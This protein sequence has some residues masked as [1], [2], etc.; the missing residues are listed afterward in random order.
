MVGTMNIQLGI[1]TPVL[2]GDI[3]TADRR[4]SS[5]GPSVAHFCRFHLR[6]EKVPPSW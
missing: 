5:N 6:L 1:G 4:A 3:R 2:V